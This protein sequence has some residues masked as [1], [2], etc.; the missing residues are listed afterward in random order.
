[1]DGR[2]R[3][4]EDW[5]LEL[6]TSKTT[7]TLFSLSTSQERVKIKLKGKDLPQSDTPAFLGIKLDTRLTWK[8]QIE[9]M[10]RKGIRKLAILKK[11]AGT[12]WGADSRLLARVYTG[13]VRP[14]M[15][16]ASTSWGTASKT[17]KS[18]LDKVQNIGLRL[19]LGAMKTTPIHDMEKTTDIEPLE[20]RRNLKVL[21]Q[22]EKMRRLPS[23]HLHHRLQQPTKNRL[24]RQSL[25]HELKALQKLHPSITSQE[26]STDL[27]Q[28]DWQLD[29]EINVPINLS[30]PGITKKDQQPAALKSLTLEMIEEK[31]PT[32]SWTHVYTDGSAEGATLNGGSGVHI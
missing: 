17:N 6:N 24:K 7:A 8:P 15:E 5:G 18:R 25:N 28:P 12:I 16:Y 20:R 2:H 27:V 10:E 29:Q 26:C 3:W 32:N 11:L 31:Y 9:E 22:G 19:I 14:T 30:V 13:A 21:M 23:H 4:T 1:M